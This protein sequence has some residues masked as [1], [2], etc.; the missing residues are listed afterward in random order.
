MPLKAPAR[1][2]VETNAREL[3]ARLSISDTS[4]GATNPAQPSISN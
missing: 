4:L 3:A 1:S 2:A